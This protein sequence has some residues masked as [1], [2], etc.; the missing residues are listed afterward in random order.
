MHGW[1]AAFHRWLPSTLLRN[2]PFV[3]STCK[4]RHHS[5]NRQTLS[6]QILF[7]TK[8][9]VVRVLLQSWHAKYHGCKAF[10]AVTNNFKTFRRWHGDTEAGSIKTSVCHRSNTARIWQLHENCSL[11]QNVAGQ[12]KVQWQK[13][14]RENL[15]QAV[16]DIVK[17]LTDWRASFAVGPR[18]LVAVR[19]VP[20]YTVSDGIWDFPWNVGKVKNSAKH[21]FTDE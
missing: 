13:V 2:V 18:R 11:I 1:F 3:S 21:G 15:R 7:C 6:C 12:K 19:F 10:W 14:L 16:N 4:Q 17:A 8:R 20:R 5:Y 9:Q